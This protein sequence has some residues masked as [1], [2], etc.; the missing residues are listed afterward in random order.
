[1]LPEVRAYVA[2]TNGWIADH[3][4]LEAGTNGLPRKQDRGIGLTSFDWRGHE[5]T[6]AVMPYRVYLLQKIQ[7]VFDAAAPEDQA[8]MAALL[9]ET[10]LSELLTLRASRRVERRDHLEVWA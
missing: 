4:N 2:Y 1:Y 10:G 6:V 9:A 8:V 7:D 3:P 5:I